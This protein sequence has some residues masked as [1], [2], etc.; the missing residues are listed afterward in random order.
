MMSQTSGQSWERPL[1]DNWIGQDN[2]SIEISLLGCEAFES[3]CLVR[4]VQVRVVD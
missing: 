4:S 1:C 2:T 3:S